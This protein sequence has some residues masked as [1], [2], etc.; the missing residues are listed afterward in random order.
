M[1]GDDRPPPNAPDK[2]A[3]IRR[4]LDAAYDVFGERGLELSTME[5]V[6]ERAQLSKQ[7]IY[8]YFGNKEGL[9]VEVLNEHLRKSHAPVLDYDYDALPPLEAIRK[10]F[11]IGYDWHLRHSHSYAIDQLSTRSKLDLSNST[12]ERYGERTTELIG[13]I[14]RRGQADGSIRQDID[15]L[16]VHV[17]IWV[18]NVGFLSSGQLFEGYMGVD[19]TTP[20]ATGTWRGLSVETII[21]VLSADRRL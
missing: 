11:E 13:T 8:Y 14:V 9:Y 5:A 1:S 10:L 2:T 7:L 6:A 19:L 18:L 20:E 3:T 17:L 12:H 21:A 15:P 16:F 4:I